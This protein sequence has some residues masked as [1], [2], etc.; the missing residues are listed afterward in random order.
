[1]PRFREVDLAI[2]LR[3]VLA[4]LRGMPA[5]AARAPW[6]DAAAAARSTPAEVALGLDVYS[7]AFVAGIPPEPAVGALLV[8][9]RAGA[10]GSGSSRTGRSP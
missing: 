2:R 6:D 9:S 8:A 5:P 3:R 7:R 10:T 1:M 4:R